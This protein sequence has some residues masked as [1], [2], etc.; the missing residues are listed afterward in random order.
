V[1]SNLKSPLL[2]I[3]LVLC[4]ITCHKVSWLIFFL[5]HIYELAWS[6]L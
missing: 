3:S 6:A 1:A 2:W 4:T 5:T